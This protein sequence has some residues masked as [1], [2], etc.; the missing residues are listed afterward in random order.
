[1]CN[2]T[3]KSSVALSAEWNQKECS[4][5]Q[6]ADKYLTPRMSR[7]QRRS[8]ENKY[9]QDDD[10]SSSGSASDNSS[11]EHEEERAQI[12][13]YCLGS[14]DDGEHSRDDNDSMVI[15]CPHDNNSPTADSDED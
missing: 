13:E 9:G 1:M 14:L 10:E 12:C 4:E 11:L 6:R 2:S 5:L 7:N 3:R 8:L 15:Y